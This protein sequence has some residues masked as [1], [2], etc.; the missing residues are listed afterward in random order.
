ME[1]LRTEMRQKMFTLEEVLEELEK[2]KNVCPG[3]H[4]G[5]KK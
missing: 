4:G 3:K 5:K 1:K 2:V